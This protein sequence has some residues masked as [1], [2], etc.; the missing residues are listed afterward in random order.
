MNLN[1]RDLNIKVWLIEV[2]LFCLNTPLFCYETNTKNG[3]TCVVEGLSIILEL[4][5]NQKVWQLTDSL[6]L[7]IIIIDYHYHA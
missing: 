4:L 6:D 5:T 7:P 1:N 3:W 2:T